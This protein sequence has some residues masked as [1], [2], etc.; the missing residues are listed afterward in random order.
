MA[1]MMRSL[2]LRVAAA[3]VA[4][5]LLIAPAAASQGPAVRGLGGVDGLKQWF[6]AN[7]THA[8]AILL[9]SPT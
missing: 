5:A 2:Q 1:A 4:A 9:L 7:R 6:N 3:L 8:R